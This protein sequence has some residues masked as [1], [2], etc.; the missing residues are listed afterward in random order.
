MYSKNTYSNF[1]KGIKMK[2]FLVTSLAFGFMSCATMASATPID[3]TGN[4]LDNGSFESGSFDPVTGHSTQSAADNWRQWINSDRNNGILTTELITNTEMQT[5]F[6]V[7]VID[8]NSA[9]RVTTSGRGDG[10]FTF[11]SYHNPGWDTGAELTFSA[12]VYTISG[13]MGLFNGSNQDG[14]LKTEST[15]IGSWEFLSVNIAAGTLNNEPLLYSVGD[16]ADFIVDSAWLNYGGTVDNPSA[17][18]PE[19]TTMLLFGTGLAGLLGYNRK[20]FN[21][22]NKQVLTAL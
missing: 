5:D 6:S 14:F 13:T 1:K 22:K 19:P 11:E 9:F 3:Q 15:T 21:K 16:A 12:W 20:Q 10:A 18:V 17:P 8:G 2:K 4:L 7:D